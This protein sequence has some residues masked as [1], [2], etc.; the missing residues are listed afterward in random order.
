V[1]TG[2]NAS[3]IARLQLNELPDGLVLVENKLAAS[4]AHLFVS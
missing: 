4:G 1:T 3:V 2:E